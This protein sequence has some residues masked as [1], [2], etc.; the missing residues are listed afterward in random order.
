MTLTTA[1]TR[2]T[3]MMPVTAVRDGKSR[4]SRNG[5]MYASKRNDAGNGNYVSNNSD[6][7]MSKFVKFVP[8]VLSISNMSFRQ[9]SVQN[10]RDSLN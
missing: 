3:I 2:A 7:K 4:N 6:E 10:G 1:V 5:I 8:L 9:N